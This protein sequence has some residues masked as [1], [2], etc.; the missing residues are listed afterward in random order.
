MSYM[1]SDLTKGPSGPQ[2]PHCI[3]WIFFQSSSTPIGPSSLQFPPRHGPPQ[4][5]PP[6]QTLFYSIGTERGQILRSSNKCLPP[7]PRACLPAPVRA[8]APAS[9]AVRVTGRLDASVLPTAAASSS[10][11]SVADFR[12]KEP[13]GDGGRFVGRSVGEERER[14]RESERRE[15]Q[16]SIF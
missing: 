6:T 4:V 14:E 12:P 7:A 3:P 10:E 1:K 8:R 9:A 2:G 11:T 13:Y 5:S 16:K 15:R